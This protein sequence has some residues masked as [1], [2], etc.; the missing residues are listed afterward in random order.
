MHEKEGAYL[1][2]GI[3]LQGVDGDVESGDLGDVVV[4]ALALLLLEL[5]RD[6]ADGA[7]L[8]TLHQVGREAGN[9][10]PKA[11]RGNESLFKGMSVNSAT[12]RVPQRIRTTSSMMRLLVWKS[13]VRRG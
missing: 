10:V 3:D 11:F 4:L 12:N 7:L 8:D 9:L 1:G 5:E 13:R 2:V 6:T